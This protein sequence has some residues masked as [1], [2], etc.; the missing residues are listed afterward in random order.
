MVFGQPARSTPFPE[1]PSTT[2]R[3]AMEEDVEDILSEGTCTWARTH[4][5]YDDEDVM[6]DALSEGE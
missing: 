6:E 5:F 3:C 2:S 4:L 1:L